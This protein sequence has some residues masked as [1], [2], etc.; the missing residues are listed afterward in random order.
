MFAWLLCALTL[1]GFA[2]EA[3]ADACLRTK[4]WDGYAD[5][6]G[7][8]T[9][10]STTLGSGKTRNYLVTLYEGNAYRIQTCADEAAEGCGHSTT[11]RAPTVQTST[12]TAW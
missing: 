5:G 11:P 6:W 8:R 4:V 2:G 9:M 12:V 7:I 3:E 10:T 1:P